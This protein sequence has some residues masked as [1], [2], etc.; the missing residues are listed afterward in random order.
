MSMW[1]RTPEP[2]VVEF[3]KATDLIHLRGLVFHGYH[4][5]LPEVSCQNV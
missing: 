4:G 3:P 2:Q 1:Q 5:V